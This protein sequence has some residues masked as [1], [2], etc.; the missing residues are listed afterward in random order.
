[1]RKTRRKAGLFLLKRASVAD[2]GAMQV[3][4]AHPSP[5]RVIVARVIA[6]GIPWEEPEATKASMEAAK[7]A[8]VE[9]MKAAAKAATVEAVKAAA[10]AAAKVGFRKPGQ[11]HG[12][13]HREQRQHQSKFHNTLL[14]PQLILA[15]GSVQILNRSGAS[16]IDYC[17]NECAFFPAPH[18]D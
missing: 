3:R 9:A 11:R 8:T 10:K 1:M 14:S 5:A 2:V 12:H 4:P 6:R 15:L 16:R 18:C 13:Q 17:R 7:A